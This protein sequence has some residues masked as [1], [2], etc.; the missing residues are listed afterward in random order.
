MCGRQR[1]CDPTPGPRK[2]FIEIGEIGT[3]ENRRIDPA[4]V[5]IADLQMGPLSASGSSLLVE[6]SEGKRHMGST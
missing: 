1:A 6:R 5:V 2:N 4:D 3:V